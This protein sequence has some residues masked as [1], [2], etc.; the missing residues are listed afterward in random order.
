MGDI[1]ILFLDSAAFGPEQEEDAFLCGS[2]AQGK[3]GRSRQIVLGY[4]KKAL[5]AVCVDNK[6]I[7]YSFPL[8]LSSPC[9]MLL[10]VQYK[11]E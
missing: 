1:C 4:A 2:A 8:F 5:L 10:S 9:A 6:N 11:K 7:K 3:Q